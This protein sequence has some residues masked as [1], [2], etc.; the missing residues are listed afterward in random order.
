M[1][2]LITWA[3]GALGRKVILIGSLVLVV[4][5]ALGLI[6]RSGRAAGRQEH[7]TK[8]SAARIQT[9]KTSQEIRHEIAQTS[10]DDLRHRL[11]RWMRD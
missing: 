8:Q 1:I 3:L 2:G 4:L 7:V 6:W 5:L 11:E 10:T 9:L